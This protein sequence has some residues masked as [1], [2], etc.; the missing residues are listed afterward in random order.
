M[1]VNKL[2]VARCSF[3]RG[4]SR[5]GFVLLTQ[6]SLLGFWRGSEGRDRIS[7]CCILQC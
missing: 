6:L 4:W 7:Q 3:R 5:A 2:R 1:F